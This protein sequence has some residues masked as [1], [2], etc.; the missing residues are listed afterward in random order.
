[1]LRNIKVTK[2]VFLLVLMYSAMWANA[3]NIVQWNM[4]NVVVEPGPYTP[5][6]TYASQIFTGND[7]MVTHG[8]VIW[9]ESDVMAPGMDVVIDDE[10]D[11]T[12]CI[13]TAGINPDDMTVKQCSDPFQSSKRFKLATTQTGTSL[14]LVFDVTDSAGLMEG[15]RVFNKLLNV[16]GKQ[17]SDINL[18]LGFGTGNQFVTVNTGQ[19]LG[20]SDR[21]GIVWVGEVTTSQTTSINLDALF[22]F[23]LFGDADT[24]PNQDVDGYF[25]D[26]NRARFELVASETRIKTTGISSNYLDTFGTFLSKSQSLSGY[27]WDHDDDDATDPLLIAHQIDSSWFTLRPDQWWIDNMLP[28]PDTNMSDGSLTDQTLD[29]WNASPDDYH[30]DFIEDLANLN[31]NF[32][33]SVG[34]FSSWPTYVVNDDSAMFTLRFSSYSVIFKDGFD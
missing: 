30:I 21:D 7:L 10:V 12:N 27:F 16:T 28:I 11:G 24:D 9:V 31:F 23:G 17:I 5:E 6:E 1:M 8:E 32:H 14:D 26:T 29:G 19:G 15:H 22:P 3:G 25:D 34:D 18:E 4:D 2:L 13:M 33:I 20:F